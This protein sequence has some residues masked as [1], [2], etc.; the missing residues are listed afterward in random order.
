MQIPQL[1][2]HDVE[3][4]PAE[5][6]KASQMRGLQP[7]APQHGLLSPVAVAAPC[8]VLDAD[9]P[10]ARAANTSKLVHRRCFVNVDMPSPQS[11]HSLIF[12]TI[13]A[14]RGS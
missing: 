2:R 7:T 1:R 13:S 3:L 6:I 14:L 5:K 9:H 8:G 4:T 11:T 12:F 10:K